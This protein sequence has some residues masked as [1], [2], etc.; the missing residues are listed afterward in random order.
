MAANWTGVGYVLSTKVTKSDMAVDPDA[1]PIW[2]TDGFLTQ[3]RLLDVHREATQTWRQPEL[4]SPRRP[5]FIAALSVNRVPLSHDDGTAQRRRDAPKF[6][7][8]SL[9][10]DDSGSNE[11]TLSV[12]RQLV[13]ARTEEAYQVIRPDVNILQRLMTLLQAG[14]VQALN[15]EARNTLLLL[16]DF[17]KQKFVGTQ[18]W[19]TIGT[20]FLFDLFKGSFAKGTYKRKQAWPVCCFG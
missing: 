12:F 15:H 18:L 13:R 2:P 9:L 5:C 3:T 1:K 7:P 14:Y 16:P 19:A 10:G 17:H 6:V 4:L 11:G 20:P 8:V